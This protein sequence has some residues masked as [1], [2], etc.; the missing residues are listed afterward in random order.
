ME[1]RARVR[2]CLLLTLAL[3]GGS[4]AGAT[5][6]EVPST[7]PNVTRQ[8][9]LTLRWALLREGG[10]AR[11][12]GL[13]EPSTPI[14]WDATLDL[15]GLDGRGRIVSRG[16]TVVRQDF[17]PGPTAFEVALVETNRETEFQLHVA[18]SR[19]TSRSGD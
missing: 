15:F 1:R 5:R 18:H 12:V 10:T 16:T 13:A 9:F 14:P 8:D 19:Q 4:C 6:I 7:L 3:A 11:A 17:A 2:T